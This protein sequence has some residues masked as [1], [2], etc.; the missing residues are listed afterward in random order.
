[1][2]DALSRLHEQV[3]F[4]KF[5]DRLKGITGVWSRLQSLQ[6]AARKD[7]AKFQ[8][9]KALL[10][11]SIE[12]LDSD[13]MDTEQTLQACKDYYAFVEQLR[14][15]F[16]IPQ[17]EQ[18]RYPASWLQWTAKWCPDAYERY[19]RAWSDWVDQP[20]SRQ[21]MERLK[22]Y[23]RELAQAYVSATKDRA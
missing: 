12:R 22:V 21:R 6:K 7:K 18:G 4:A 16:G 23:T 17:H 2:S 19:S 3:Q 1:M 15:Q 14:V 5:A 20:P 13:E 11:K 9:Y 10:T 8:E